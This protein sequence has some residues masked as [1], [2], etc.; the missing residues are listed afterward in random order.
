MRHAAI[1][2]DGRTSVGRLAEDGRTLS[3]P[4][5]AHRP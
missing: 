4:V 3:G 2:H 5:A 1:E